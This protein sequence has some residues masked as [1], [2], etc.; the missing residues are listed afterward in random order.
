MIALKG[1]VSAHKE[2]LREILSREEY[3]E[4]AVSE[5]RNPIMDWLSDGW[6]RLLELL[7]GT[8][9][10]SGAPRALAYVLLVAVFA[11][12]AAGIALLARNLIVRR[13][14]VRR[15]EMFR[16]DGEL[17]RSSRAQREA[18][19][20]EA[21]QGRFEEAVRLMFLA[22]LLR[23]DEL[24]W[25]RAEKWKT[26]LE[27]AEELAGRRPEAVQSFS[28]AAGVFENV[29]YGQQSA[30]RGDYERLADIAA[31]HWREGGAHA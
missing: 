25:I 27:Y 16:G 13:Q 24:G 1:D 17:E 22:M 14:A 9:V 2:K 4:Q 19:E 7:S 23:M 18:A 3:R 11:L 12:L 20:R 6:N 31:P 5:R 29:F 30:G 26:N 8:E 15:I 28:Q 21:E 10:P